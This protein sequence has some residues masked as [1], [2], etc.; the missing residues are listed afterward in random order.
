MYHTR[1]SDTKGKLMKTKNYS[2][3]VIKK[4]DAQI[5]HE[6]TKIYS[7]P[8][9][10]SQRK[11]KASWKEIFYKGY[12]RFPAVSLPSPEIKANYSLKHALANRT[13]DRDYSS[14]SLSALELSNLLYFSA[15]LQKQRNRIERRYYPSAGARYPLE[16]YA[17]VLNVEGIPQGIYHYYLK[18]HCLERLLEPPFRKQ[19]FSNFGQPWLK[20]S[21]VVFLITAVF[22]RNE[23]KYGSRGYRHV[24]T[25]VGHLS[26]NL[27]LLSSSMGV[28]CCSVGGYVDDGVNKLLDIDGLEESVVG[29]T[30]LGHPG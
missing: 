19:L 18:S 5:F 13:S 3:G 30:V 24:L 23:V 16:V 8:N 15:G 7:F 20:K 22:Y 2:K 17:A 6:K 11:W 9:S 28:S 21:A 27:Y 1:F 10:L 12:P 4:T 26:Q 25:E 29:V 14:K